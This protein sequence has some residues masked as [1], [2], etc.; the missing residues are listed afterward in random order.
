MSE[1]SAFAF[2]PAF[3]RTLAIEVGCAL[4]LDCVTAAPQ[5]AVSSA[6]A[7]RSTRSLFIASGIT[8]RVGSA[9]DLDAP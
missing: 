5:A 8:Q 3:S 7:T 1:I 9:D 4:E 6:D 2:G